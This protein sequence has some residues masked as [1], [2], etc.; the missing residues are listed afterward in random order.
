M[1]LNQHRKFKL[2]VSDHKEV[3]CSCCQLSTSMLASTSEG[4][5][6]AAGVK[7]SNFNMLRSRRVFLHLFM[8]SIRYFTDSTFLINNLLCHIVANLCRYVADD[9]NMNPSPT[10]NLAHLFSAVF[11]IWF[12]D[13]HSPSESTCPQTRSSVPFPISFSSDDIRCCWLTRR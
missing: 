4:N 1:R 13:F 10:P 11:F 7:N 12:C 8:Q 2:H 6:A 9:N 5:V 3:V